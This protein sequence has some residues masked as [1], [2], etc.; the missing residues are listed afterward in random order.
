MDVPSCTSNPHARQSSCSIWPR[1]KRCPLKSTGAGLSV[2]QDILG[3]ASP[4]TTKRIYAT[5]DREV[6]RFAARV[7][8]PRVEPD[9]LALQATV[10]SSKASS[11]CWSAA[12]C[13]RRRPRPHCTRREIR[14]LHARLRPDGSTTGVT[15]GSVQSTMRSASASCTFRLQDLVNSPALSPP[16]RAR[17]RA[18]P[19]DRLATVGVPAPV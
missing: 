2:V 18:V 13:T 12:L 16:K 11:S 9:S 15:A 1:A 17:A 6:L 19:L 5:S 4:A 10:S 8:A 7:H 14:W 3:H